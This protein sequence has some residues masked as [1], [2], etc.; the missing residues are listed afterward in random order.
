L[1]PQARFRFHDGLS[2]QQCQFVVGA[3]GFDRGIA[4]GA[5]ILLSA[6]ALQSPSWPTVTGAKLR[7]ARR[8]TDSYFSPTGMQSW[9][10]NWNCA[11]TGTKSSA[12]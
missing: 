4:A 1:T 2:R 7:A 9:Q 5:S 10:P 12:A 8:R 3:A 11:E 6:R